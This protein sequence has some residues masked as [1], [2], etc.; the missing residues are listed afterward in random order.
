MIHGISLKKKKTQ[1]VRNSF[2]VGTIEVKLV[3]NA[4]IWKKEYFMRLLH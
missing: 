4:K 1:D 2:T 3:L